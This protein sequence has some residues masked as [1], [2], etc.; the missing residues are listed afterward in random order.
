MGYFVDKNYF[1]PVRSKNRPFVEDLPI[2]IYHVLGAFLSTV[3]TA[4]NKKQEIPNLSWS[5]FLWGETDYKEENTSIEYD[6]ARV[7]ARK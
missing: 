4:Q 1:S 7:L 3:G 5:K 6:I 2:Q